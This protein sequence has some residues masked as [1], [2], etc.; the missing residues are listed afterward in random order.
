MKT[1]VYVRKRNGSATCVLCL[2][3]GTSEAVR[4][5]V[6]WLHPKRL[7]LGAVTMPG[8]AVATFGRHGSCVAD[9]RCG[10]WL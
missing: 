10:C 7:F 6:I 9:F 8:I 4:I 3:H 5:R 2:G 1:F